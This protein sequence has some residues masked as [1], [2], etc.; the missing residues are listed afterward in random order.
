MENFN[1]FNVQK[2]MNKEA[3]LEKVFNDIQLNSE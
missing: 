3:F 2:A 1:L